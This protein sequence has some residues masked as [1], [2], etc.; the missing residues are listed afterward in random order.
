MPRHPQLQ[1]TQMW[2]DHNARHSQ[3]HTRITQATHEQCIST[4]Y[5]RGGISSLLQIN[6][7]KTN[8]CPTM[9]AFALLTYLGKHMARAAA[10]TIHPCR[11]TAELTSLLKTLLATQMSVISKA[12]RSRLRSLGTYWP[13]NICPAQTRVSMPLESPNSDRQTR[14]SHLLQLLARAVMQK[15][16]VS[17]EWLRYL[18]THIH[19][20]RNVTCYMRTYKSRN[21]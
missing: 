8:A 11:R 4:P 19:E 18:L 15:V 16:R 2:H 5:Q 6:A 9:R 17:R 7:A 14:A 21:I 10:R 1:V 20:Y 3:I 12:T 13:Y